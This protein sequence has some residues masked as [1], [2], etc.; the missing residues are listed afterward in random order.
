MC[1]LYINT[2]TW[3]RYTTFGVDKSLIPR[4]SRG[5]LD[6]KRMYAT[7]KWEE[8]N[9]LSRPDV[10]QMA[11]IWYWQQTTRNAGM[12]N[13][14]WHTAH[15]SI[16]SCH[17][18]KSRL[19]KSR[20]H[21]VKSNFFFS[22]ISATVT[23]TVCGNRNGHA[24]SYFYDES[25]EILFLPCFPDSQTPRS[26]T[27]LDRTCLFIMKCITLKSWYISILNSQKHK[28]HSMIIYQYIFRWMALKIKTKKTFWKILKKCYSYLF[29]SIIF[30]KC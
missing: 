17:I 14:V 2:C 29:L 7:E 9:R 11:Q 18:F 25:D 8:G 4:E 27:P 13:F 24:W 15:E 30:S 19:Q 6:G 5:G 21:L 20:I 12:M 1:T 3:H 22:Q 23:P 10:S 28:L 16:T 26:L